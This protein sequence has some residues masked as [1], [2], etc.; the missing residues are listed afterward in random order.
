MFHLVPFEDVGL[1]APALIDDENGDQAG[2]RS[3]D[4][5]RRRALDASKGASEE[6]ASQGR[7]NVYRRSKDVRRYVLARAN[8][9]CE[10]C[11]LN[12]PF[13]STNGIPYLEPHHIRRLSDGGPDHPRWVAGICPN[14]HREIHFGKDGKE[15]NSRLSD[16]IGVLEESRSEEE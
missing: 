2:D 14:C 1:T 5:L 16:K 7:R 13:E 10:S 3:L 6:S 11:D 8:G 4:E 15:L 9:K 12:A